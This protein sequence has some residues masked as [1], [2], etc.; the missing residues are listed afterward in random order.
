MAWVNAFLCGVVFMVPIEPVRLTQYS[1]G[2][3]CGCKISPTFL[4]RILKSDATAPEGQRLIVGNQ[5]RDDAAVYDLQNGFGLICTTDFFMP[6]VD[7]PFEFGQVAAANAMSDVYAMGGNPILAI[8][9]LGWPVNKLSAEIAQRVL[10]GARDMCQKAGIRLAGGHSIDNPEPLFGLAVNGLVEIEHLKQND[11][12][13]TGDLL[14][15]T[16]PLGIGI[17]TTAG[18]KGVLRRDDYKS[19]LA[20]MIQ[21]NRVG[22]PLGKLKGVKAM[23]DVTGFGLLGHL[24][25]MCESSKLNAELYFEDIPRL[26]NLEHYLEQG[27]VTG[28]G[29]RNWASYGD[30]VGP[31]S[32][33]ERMVLSDPQTNGGLLV[34]VDPGEVD[35]FKTVMREEQMEDRIHR[36]GRFVER[37]ADEVLI[38]V[39]SAR[40]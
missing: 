30:K 34:A 25:E 33:L 7:D 18:K 5:S 24:K 21:L 23:T 16:K 14:F 3:G 13:E 40:L 37:T 9:I 31:L 20:E 35:A 19:V 36:V 22:M 1:H 6:I 39:K 2:G 10:S 29:R 12:A 15:L 32:D 11:T 27:C 17:I 4:D 8:A 26:P 28:G 38:H